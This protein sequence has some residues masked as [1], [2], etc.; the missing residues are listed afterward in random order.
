MIN[1]ERKKELYDLWLTET[2]EEA[3]TNEW[4]NSLTDEEKALVSQWDEKFPL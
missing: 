4:F 2:E 3:K 1:E